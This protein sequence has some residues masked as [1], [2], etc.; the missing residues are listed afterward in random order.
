MSE[1]YSDKSILQIC[2]EERRERGI[3]KE[4]V[5]EKLEEI[6]KNGGSKDKKFENMEITELVLDHKVISGIDNHPIVFENCTFIEGISIEDGNISLPMIFINCSIGG[7]NFYHARFEHDIEFRDSTI[8]GSVSFDETKFEQDLEF[9]NVTFH[10]DVKVLESTF[11]DDTSFCESTFNKGAKFERS[12]FNGASNKFDDNASFSNSIFKNSTSF[13]GSNFTAVQFSGTSFEQDVTF[14][15]AV[16]S[17]DS[18]FKE[19]TVHGCARFDKA[20]WKDDV[21]FKYAVF[22][23]KANFEGAI[24]QG[25]ADSIE[26]DVEFAEAVFNGVANFKKSSF[27]YSNFSQVQFNSDTIFTEATFAADADFD[28][29]VFSKQVNFE[30]ARFLEDA[31]FAESHFMD[32]VSFAGA[33]FEGEANYKEENAD[34]SGVVFDNIVDF[35]KTKFSSA[36]FTCIKI[37]NDICFEHSTIDSLNI[38]ILKNNKD[39]IANFANAIIKN[40]SIVQPENDWTP[41]DLTN[42]SLGNVDISTPKLKPD[43]RLFNYFRFC[44]TIFDEFDGSEFDFSDHSR[45]LNRN[46][47]NLHSFISVKNGNFSVDMTP[48]TIE[49]TYLN[50][51]NSASSVGD[52][53]A[54]GEFRT[55]RQRFA[56][57]KRYNVLKDQSASLRSRVSNGVRALEIAFLGLTC[58]YG[59]RI[60]RIL[61]AFAVIPALFTP[62]YA[63]G[64]KV[65]ATNAGQTTVSALMTPEGQST[66]F[67]L[68]SF[69]YITFLT[70]GYG[71]IGPQGWGARILV[72]IQVYLNVILGGLVLYA[73]IKRSEI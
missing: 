50:A 8:T 70:I 53:H 71:N 16:F 73:L 4:N 60:F 40:G 29:V 5:C 25:G 3:T 19:I 34:F 28:N 7:L 69:S 56:R 64:G 6:L 14:T 15:E 17:G 68:L 51:K 66:F 22:E 11:G 55:K 36:N 10:Q 44:K 39:L 23:N 42:V 33:V 49:T 63:F 32:T 65:F 58:G 31:D 9:D 61:G 59:I 2:P 52:M 41:Y 62:F 37:S 26:D 47:W 57:R 30:E 43:K 67:E 27:N 38:Q 35:S 46:N 48:E 1:D 24:F 21:N 72:A 45:Y 13:D 20:H 18:I 12:E 54:A